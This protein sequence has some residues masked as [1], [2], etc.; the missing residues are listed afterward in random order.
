MTQRK[1]A[2]NHE[3]LHKSEAKKFAKFNQVVEYIKN[4]VKKI[5]AEKIIYLKARYKDIIN[6]L[7]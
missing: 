5:F 4:Q 6:K 1:K 2:I 7:A 3:I